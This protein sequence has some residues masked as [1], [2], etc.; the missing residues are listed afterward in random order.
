M[1]FNFQ[2]DYEHRFLAFAVLKGDNYIKLTPFVVQLCSV[3]LKQY[4]YTFIFCTSYFSIG[5]Y[6]SLLSFTENNG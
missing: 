1:L 3:F 2:T 6:K 5:S 4:Q